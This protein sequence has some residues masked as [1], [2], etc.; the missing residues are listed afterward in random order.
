[1]RV[2][3]IDS[4]SEDLDRL[5]AA[6]EASCVVGTWDWDHVR[7]VVTYDAGAARLLAGDPE[8]VDREISGASAAAAV[9]PADREWLAEHM[10]RAARAGGLVLA[11]YRV[12]ASDGAVHWLLSRGR[13]YQDDVGRPVRS[14][15]I[16]IDITEMR[17]DGERYVLGN[18]PASE[19]PLDR[20]AELAIMLKQ[21]LGADAPSDVLLMADLMLISLGR[22]IAQRSEE[23]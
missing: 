20:A 11:E 2:N 15:G 18:T 10:K 8:L 21:G 4:F 9:H 5:H 19:H 16:L 22:A 23:R 6:L 14:R 1:M 13:T 17:D 7:G 12:L 3:T